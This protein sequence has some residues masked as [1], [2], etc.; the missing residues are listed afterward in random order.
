MIFSRDRFSNLNLKE[1]SRASFTIID[2]LQTFSPEAKVAAIATVFKL[3][4]DSVSM[5]IPELMDVVNNIMHDGD[6]RRP[7]FKAISDYLSHEMR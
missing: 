2:S 3:Y 1:A 5:S 6:T 7:E 4:A